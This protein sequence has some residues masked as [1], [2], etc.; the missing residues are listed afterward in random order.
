MVIFT[1]KKLA[2]AFMLVLALVLMIM[3]FQLNQ[4]EKAH[5][6]RATQITTEKADYLFDTVIPLINNDAEKL[7]AV[8]KQE[9]IDV[10]DRDYVDKN[11]LKIEILDNLNGRSETSHAM[12]TIGEIVKGVTLNNVPQNQA[13]NNDIIILMRNPEKNEYVIT[14]DMSENCATE[15]RFRNVNVEVSQQFAKALFRQAYD[16][17]AK[18]K[19]FTFWSFLPVSEEK[20]W[21]SDVLNMT[22]T[23]MYD[24]K[25]YFIKYQG[26]MESLR[27]FEFLIS[28]KIYRYEDYFGMRTKNPN[29]SLTKEDMA[30]VVISGYNLLDQLEKYPLQKAHLLT[31]ESKLEEENERFLT[32]KAQNEIFSL[33]IIVAFIMLFLYTHEHH[34]TNR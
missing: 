28:D 30:I 7:V 3:K 4:K 15:D 13:D 27:S 33:I 23:Q 21:Y 2:T 9:M 29:G 25:N 8:K 5:I 6:I 18:N 32:Y 31:Y 10:F 22:S 11:T 34:K 1:M 12:A 14:I 20:E 24:L 19:T 16:D 17:F 26:D